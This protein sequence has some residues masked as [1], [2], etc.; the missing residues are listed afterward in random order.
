H[1]EV[2]VE[3]DIRGSYPRTVVFLRRLEHLDR[4]VH[5]RD[6]KLERQNASG[7]RS[8]LHASCTALVYRLLDAQDGGRT[9]RAGGRRG[10]RCTPPSGRA[11]SPRAL[12]GAP[13]A[14][15]RPVRAPPP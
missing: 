2:Q 11:A 5:V 4:L 8:V 9:R 6:L 14:P 15:G 13:R 7:G 3:L 10:R 1:V 12:P